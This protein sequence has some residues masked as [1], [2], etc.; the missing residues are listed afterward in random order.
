[1]KWSFIF[2]SDIH[3]GTPRSFRFQPAWN[4]HWRTAREQIVELDPEFLI[5]GGDLTRD[6]DTH[7]FELEQIKADLD[8]LPFAWHAIP[9]NHEVGSKFLAGSD[10][11]INAASVALYRSVLGDSHWSFDHKG[12]R[13]SGFNAFLA[14]SGL[15]AEREMWEWLEQQIKRPRAQ[16]HVWLMHPALFIDD[17]HEPNWDV[18]ENHDEWYFSIDEPHRNRFMQVFQETGA[19]LVITGHIHCRRRVEANG[20]VFQHAPATAFPQW[21]DRWVDGDATLGV[22][23]GTV[24]DEAI[25]LEFVP[26]RET[27]DKKGYGPG[28]NIPLNGRDYTMAWETPALDPDE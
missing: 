10:V 11:S 27:S 16:R 15:P 22:L 9:G 19:E 26:L 28:G 21:Y 23:R 18:R 6:G 8:T 4:E 12:V 17:L 14:G 7:R 24:S 20:I 5:V 25:D 3:V 1:M 2:A 13:F